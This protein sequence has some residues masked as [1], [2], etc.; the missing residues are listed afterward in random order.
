MGYRHVVPEIEGYTRQ[1]VISFVKLKLTFDNKWMLRGFLRLWGNQTN[2]EKMNY[3]SHGHN[4]FG[5]NK[6]D[7][8]MMTTIYRRYQLE[9]RISDGHM[10]YLKG[11]IPKYAAQ[12]SSFSDEKKLKKLMDEYFNFAKLKLTDNKKYGFKTI[13][14]E[15]KKPMIIMDGIGL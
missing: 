13:N 1:Q 12:I 11:K 8:L 10:E 2:S 3:I 9:K 5:F 15:Q 14:K 4:H 7:S 6:I